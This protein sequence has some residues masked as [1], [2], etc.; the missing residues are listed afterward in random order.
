MDTKSPAE[1]PLPLI[2]M[3]RQK[4]SER[5]Y[6]SIAVV[7]LQ[8]KSACGPDAPAFAF[9]VSPFASTIYTTPEPE[10]KK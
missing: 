3:Q 2:G 4:R 10:D 5:S 1:L 7:G 9:E 8:K 6:S